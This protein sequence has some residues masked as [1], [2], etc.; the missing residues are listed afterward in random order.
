M[1]TNQKAIEM[2][3]Q[4]EYE[5]AMELFQQAVLESRNVQSLNNLAWMY[6]YE[7]DD[8]DKAIELIIQDIFQGELQA[9][10]KQPTG[11]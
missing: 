1:N 2:F 3:E 6:L 10:L 7:E 11:C 5:E 9:T 4:N 8:D